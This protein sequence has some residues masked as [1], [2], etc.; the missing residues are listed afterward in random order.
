[1]HSIKVKILKA[2]A[3]RDDLVSPSVSLK[4][5]I[6]SSPKPRVPQTAP[7]TTDRASLFVAGDPQHAYSRDGTRQAK[8]G[9]NK[10]DKEAMEKQRDKVLQMK[11][12]LT[13]LT[14][15]SIQK[16]QDILTMAKR[17][18]E[19]FRQAAF[20]VI[21]KAK[22]MGIDP[23]ELEQTIGTASI[24]E[25]NSTMRS[26]SSTASSRP[27]FPSISIDHGTATGSLG[28][29]ESRRRVFFQ[30]GVGHIGYNPHF[31]LASNG[32]K[33]DAHALPLTPATYSQKK[34]L[35]GSVRSWKLS[36]PQTGANWKPIHACIEDQVRTNDHSG[37]VAHLPG[38]S[39]SVAATN[40]MLSKMSG[41][42]TPPT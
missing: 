35:G 20:S 33:P 25:S 2:Y 16:R 12:P 31:N 1:M 7:T 18:Q 8:L 4:D 15:V 30:D 39:S 19:E 36:R 40:R 27:S 14:N 32:N 5:D 6:L 9:K 10:V 41:L 29:G 17:Q 22:E 13:P 38:M 3:L 21:Q 37:F 24:N 28:A 42:P 34:P 26:S 11:S 23:S